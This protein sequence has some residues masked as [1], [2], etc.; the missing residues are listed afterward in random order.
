[1]AQRLHVK[2]KQCGGRNY[3]EPGNVA[4][5]YQGCFRPLGLGRLTGDAWLVRG[6]PGRP[7]LGGSRPHQSQYGS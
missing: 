6:L 1:V 5:L 4:Q 7:N 2:S 3:R